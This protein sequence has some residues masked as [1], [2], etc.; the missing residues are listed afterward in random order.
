MV[1]GLAF[2]LGLAFG[3]GLPFAFDFV[4]RS[5]VLCVGSSPCSRWCWDMDAIGSAGFS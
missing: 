5:M 2:A 3:L 4:D 1:L